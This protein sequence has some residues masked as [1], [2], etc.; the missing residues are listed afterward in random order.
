MDDTTNTGGMPSTN[1]AAPSTGTDTGTPVAPAW[2]PPVTG[3]AAPTGT[4]EPVSGMPTA[5]PEPGAGMPGG[6]P[7][8][9]DP[10]MPGAGTGE[11]APT[12]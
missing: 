2:V 1:P 9:T 12:V 6:M 11:P 4:T 10:A 5:A 8:A 3:P 7:P